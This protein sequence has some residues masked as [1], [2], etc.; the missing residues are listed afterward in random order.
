MLR[1]NGALTDIKRPPLAYRPCAI[2]RPGTSSRNARRP[3]YIR[4]KASKRQA[5]AADIHAAAD[6]VATHDLLAS[7]IGQNPPHSRP[8]LPSE[9]PCATGEG[10]M[11]D[12]KRFVSARQAGQRVSPH[13]AMRARKRATSLIHLGSTWADIGLVGM[14]RRDGSSHIIPPEAGLLKTGEGAKRRAETVASGSPTR[15]QQRIR[16]VLRRGAMEGETLRCVKVGNRQS[17]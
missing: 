13:K 9:L 4:R 14:A 12:P 11:T 3:M 7:P 8:E 1:A 5:P 15:A 16:C 2:C 10:A 6:A 17:F